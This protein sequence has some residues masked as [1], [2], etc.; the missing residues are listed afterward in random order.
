MLAEAISPHGTNNL[1]VPMIAAAVA[2]L[3]GG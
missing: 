3:V 1:S 2:L